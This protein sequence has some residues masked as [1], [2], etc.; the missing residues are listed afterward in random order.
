VPARTNLAPPLSIGLVAPIVPRPKVETPRALHNV[1]NSLA[2]ELLQFDTLYH[3]I[4]IPP[5]RPEFL[6][7]RLSPAKAKEAKVEDSACLKELNR[8]ARLA[9]LAPRAD[10]IAYPIYTPLAYHVHDYNYGKGFTSPVA[11]KLRSHLKLSSDNVFEDAF[12]KTTRPRPV[13]HKGHPRF[14]KEEFSRLLTSKLDEARR[15]FKLNHTP[16]CYPRMVTSWIC[17]L[18]KAPAAKT[19]KPHSQKKGTSQKTPSRENLD[20]VPA[21]DSSSSAPPLPQEPSTTPRPTT[22]SPELSTQAIPDS[23]IASAIALCLPKTKA[24]ASRIYELVSPMLQTS[25]YSSIEL[26]DLSRRMLRLICHAQLSSPDPSRISRVSKE[27]GQQLLLHEVIASI[28]IGVPVLPDS[29][30]CSRPDSI[31]ISVG[32]VKRYDLLRTCLSDLSALY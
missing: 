24:S 16:K 27:L 8:L 31:V 4:R 25:S 6:V 22:P 13:F 23:V 2:S 12:P 7:R 26:R 32:Y 11:T 14:V 18:F 21:Q 30:S 20:F 1:L 10:N 28:I 15:F 9:E 5:S 29:D 19:T 17:A 3:E